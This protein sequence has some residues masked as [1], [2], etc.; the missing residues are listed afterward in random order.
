MRHI[1]AL[2]L[3]LLTDPVSAQDTVAEIT[4][5]AAVKDG[6]GILFGRVE[7]RLQGIAAPE[8]N[9]R[10]KEPGGRESLYS[11]HRLVQG[12]RVICKLDGTTASSNRPVGIC[13]LNGVDIG[14]YQ[15]RIGQARDCPRFSNGRY[16]QLERLAQ[17]SGKNLKGIYALPTYCEES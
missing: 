11:L 9:N 10:K 12:K 13:Y 3:L 2:V 7:I 1:L 8:Y 4:G 14:A 6:D 5:I 15:V 17:E 16:F